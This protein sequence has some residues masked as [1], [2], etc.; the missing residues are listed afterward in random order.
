MLKNEATSNIK[1]FQVLKKLDFLYS[2]PKQFIISVGVYCFPEKGLWCV[3]R[4]LLF[5]TE[6]CILNSHPTKELHGFCLFGKTVLVNLILHFQQKF[7]TKCNS[8]E[9]VFILDNPRGGKDS[10]CSCH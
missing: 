4:D 7:P 1:I 3:N 6:S 8:I 2:F 9:R 5:T 10:I